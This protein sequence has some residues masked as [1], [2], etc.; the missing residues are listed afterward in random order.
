MDP[1]QTL[2]FTPIDHPDPRVHRIGFDLTHPY[3]EQCWSAVVGP[4][5]TLLLRRISTL[6]MESVPARIEAAELSRSLGLGAGVGERSRLANTLSRLTQ[7]GLA[8]T[9]TYGEG[10]DVYR[11][12]APLGSRQLARVPEWTRTTH[13]QLFGHHLEQVENLDQHRSS[14]ATMSA[15]LDR[16][17]FSQQSSNALQHPGQAIEL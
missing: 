4:S 12:I 6:W 10:L 5:S 13:E 7:F 9:S 16:L 1:D 3:V 2:A 11:Q 17:Q 15:R 14:A 8:K